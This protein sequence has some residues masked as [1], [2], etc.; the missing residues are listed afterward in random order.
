M[1]RS[2][3][4]AHELELMLCVVDIMRYLNVL[5]TMPVYKRGLITQLSK[6]GLFV[7]KN[8]QVNLG[9]NSAS[10]A[11]VAGFESSHL[12]APSSQR[13]IYKMSLV[14]DVIWSLW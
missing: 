4:T 3:P 13:C 2:P 8:P 1:F 12:T 10:T 9:T 14:I 5:F 7:R 6:G 11:L